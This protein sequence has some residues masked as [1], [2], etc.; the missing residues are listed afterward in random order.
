MRP[1]SASLK[2]FSVPPAPGSN[3]SVSATTRRPRAAIPPL[4]PV[5]LPLILAAIA[6]NVLFA[7]WFPAAN[8]I[9][10]GPVARFTDATRTAGINFVHR[11][12]NSPSPTSIDGGVAV[13]DANGDGHPDLFFVNGAP[14]PWADNAWQTPATSALLL[15]DGSGRFADVTAD[16]GLRVVMNGMAAVTGDYDNDGDADLFVTCIGRNR[17]FR[18]EGGAR[19]TEVTDEAGVGGEDHDWSTGAAWLDYDGDGQ[20]DLIVTHYLRWPPEFGLGAAFN[21]ARVGRSYGTPVRFVS[22]FPT[23]LRNRGDGRFEPVHDQAGLQPIDPLT[24]FP[25]EKTLAI[26]VLDAN[27]DGRLDLLLTFHTGEPAL[28]LNAGN[29]R[30]APWI[31]ADA[32][33]HE[34]LTAAIAAAGSL[35]FATVSNRDDLFP[36]LRSFTPDSRGRD[37]GNTIDLVT[38]LG[39]VPL[40][41]DLDGRRELFV[42][43]AA[44]EPDLARIA[45]DKPFPSAPALY[46]NSGDNWTEATPA[47]DQP[48]PA[49]GA[50]RGVAAADFDGDGDLDLALARNQDGAAYWRND[51]RPGQPWLRVSLQATRSH[52]SAQGARVELHTPR[53]VSIRTVA[54]ALGYLSQSDDALTFGLGEDDRIRRLVIHWP[55]GQRQE[56]RGLAI[57]QHLRLVEP[58]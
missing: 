46:W 19:F 58:D 3:R 23:V 57:N 18:N 21:F 55:S 1:A 37:F 20:L 35:P 13:F 30:F 54:P 49:A 10:S 50:V 53:H 51:L 39:L 42:P 8:E 24:G 2:T 26:G 48:W 38:K 12:G 15:N 4:L 17:L 47:P 34:G 44:I 11:H 33:R 6:I 7:V 22:L 40:D 25:R 16:A 14:W 41:Y 56:L 45:D 29:G 43:H 31:S 52:R 36:M 32:V 5:L 28:F 27:Q 9:R